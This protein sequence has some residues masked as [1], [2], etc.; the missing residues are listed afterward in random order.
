MSL[1]ENSNTLEKYITDIYYAST[2]N[3]NLTDEEKSSAV[4]FVQKF[5]GIYEKNIFNKDSSDVTTTNLIRFFSKYSDS[6]FI[7]FLN[8]LKRKE[9]LNY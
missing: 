5:I 7:N 1:E 6:V 2:G 9:Q 3:E 4:D 8:V